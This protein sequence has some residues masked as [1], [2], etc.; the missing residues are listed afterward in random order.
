MKTG[1]EGHSSLVF[2]CITYFKELYK[3]TKEST[4]TKI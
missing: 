2:K 4:D 3:K 1:T